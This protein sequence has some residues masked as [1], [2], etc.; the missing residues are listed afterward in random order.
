MLS[1]VLPTFNESQNLERLLPILEDI[2]QAIPHEI[3]VVD[4]DSPDRTWETA[5]H[6]ARKDSSMKVIRRIGRRGLSSAVVEGFD[7]AQGDVLAVMDCDGQHDPR[8]LPDLYRAIQAGAHLATASRYTRGGSTGGWGGPRLWLSRAATLLTSHL[9]R[10][11]VSDPMS[12][13]FA[14]RRNTFVSIAGELRPQGFKILLEILAHLPRDTRTAEVPLTF[15]ERWTGESKLSLRVQWQF[16]TQL[17]RIA[18]GRIRE[19]LWQAQWVVLFLVFFIMF[20]ALLPRAWAL[21]L[22]VL[23]PSVRLDTQAALR[24]ITEQEGWLLSDIDLTHASETSIR[25]FHHEHR[26]GEDPSQCYILRF[27]P[28]ILIPCAE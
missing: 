16:L 18:L 8:L 4:D 6:L 15:G 26:R 20:V 19:F 2:L 24:Q 13:Y 12:G 1:L 10:V 28:L 23:N 14:L 3:I 9:P 27:E 7:V 5:E 22:L 17:A 25:F 11:H 21:R